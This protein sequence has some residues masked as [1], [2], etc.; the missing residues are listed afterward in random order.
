MWYPLGHLRRYTNLLMLAVLALGT[1]FAFPR[2]LKNIDN[3]FAVTRG[4][5]NAQ[6]GPRRC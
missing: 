4:C 2:K 3:S 6:T 5:G 1:L